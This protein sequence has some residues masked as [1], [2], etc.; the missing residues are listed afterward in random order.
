MLAAE[1]DDAAVQVVDLRRRARLHV[2]EHARLVAVGDVGPRGV[3]DQLL[4][5]GVELDP[6]RG[7]DGLALVHEP[8]D[9]RAEVRPLAHAAVRQAGE[10]A[11]RVRRRVEDHLPPLRPARVGHRRRRHPAAGARVGQPLDLLRGRR[12]RLE[13]PEGRVALARPTARR[14][15]RGSSR[16]G[17]S[18]RGS[19]GATCAA[20]VSSLPTPFWTDATA[21]SAKACAVAAIAASVCIAFVATIPKSH[22]GSSAAS[23]V[24]RSR[25]ACTSPAPVRRR[26][27]SL[28]AAT[29]ASARSYAH[30]STSSRDARFAAK[31]LPT[32]PQPDDADPHAGPP[33]QP[34]LA[35]ARDP[36][37]PEHEHQR[38]QRA[39]HDQPRSLRQKPSSAFPST[40]SSPLTASAPT[41]APQRLV[42]PPTTSIASVRKVSSR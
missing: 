40:E 5:V 21:P 3:V 28:I 1:A 26:P 8:A 32:A 20:I 35:A 16:P 10:R 11:D 2:L 25:V 37:R 27:R 42:I 15:A 7:G 14:P 33:R 6:L 41:T 9:E 31:R 18:C 12:A 4:G 19:R 29:C 36:G 38:H 30:T 17:T 13:R 24:A 22:A 39:E 34:Q 23:L